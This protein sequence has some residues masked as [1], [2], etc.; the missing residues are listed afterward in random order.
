MDIK[1]RKIS[2]VQEFLTLENETNIRKLEDLLRKIKQHEYAQRL[3]TDID[4]AL[5]DSQNNYGLDLEDLKEDVK[6]WE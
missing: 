1:G 6:K 5:E 4:Q 3:N 2:F